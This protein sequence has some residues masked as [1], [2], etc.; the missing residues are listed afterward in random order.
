MLSGGGLPDHLRCGS[1]LIYLTWPR[2]FGAAVAAMAAT[3]LW[4]S[5]LTMFPPPGGSDLV[6]S[7]VAP[8]FTFSNPAQRLTPQ[9]GGGMLAGLRLWSQDKPASKMRPQMAIKA[10]PMDRFC[11]HKGSTNFLDKVSCKL[12]PFLICSRLFVLYRVLCTC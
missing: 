3:L 2:L 11:E 6:L 5:L 12:L 9:S 1:K 4:T 10:G 7:D 8:P